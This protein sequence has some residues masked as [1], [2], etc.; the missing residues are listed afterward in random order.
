MKM[1]IGFDIIILVLLL[2]V[3]IVITIYL[4]VMLTNK[5]STLI[6]HFDKLNGKEESNDEILTIKGKKYILASKKRR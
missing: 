5:G 3:L 6:R 4:I 2:I 1:L